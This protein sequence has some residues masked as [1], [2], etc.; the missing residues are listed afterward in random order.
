V[1]EPEEHDCDEHVM[2]NINDEE[3]VQEEVDR[4]PIRHP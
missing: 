1:E 4:P 2:G 3:Q